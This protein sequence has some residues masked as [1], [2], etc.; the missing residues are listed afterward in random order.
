MIR[1]RRMAACGKSVLGAGALATT[2]AAIA[3][4]DA[5]R[6]D[7]IDIAPDVLTTGLMAHYTFDEG[8]GTTVFDHSGNKRD[9]VLTGGAWIADGRFGGALHF[10]G[11]SLV[12]VPNFPDAP[13]DF[14]VSTWVRSTDLPDDAGYQTVVSTELVF[15]AGWQ[16]N[17]VKM[18]GGAVLQG[19]FW[20]RVIDNYTYYD[21]PCLPDE[22]WTH[23]VFVVDGSAQTFTVYINGK[24]ES[25]VAAPASI[26]P[27]SPSL[28]MGTWTRGGRLL[29][30][31][32]DDMA[33]YA[34]AL[35]QAEITLL[36]EGP[37]PDVQ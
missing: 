26:L 8:S 21:C 18:P 14:S 10:D 31:D 29:V 13:S 1:L 22:V 34:R 15:D 25:V 17:V 9:G 28:L 7:A 35:A 16:L 2:A 20:D 6:L 12:T 27:G 24:L 37:P 30:G 3:G 23:F 11:K 4:C 36:D 19:A 32:L 5:G 33:I